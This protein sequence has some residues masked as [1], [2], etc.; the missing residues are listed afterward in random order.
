M[1]LWTLTVSGNI[2]PD[3]S[4]HVSNAAQVGLINK[5]LRIDLDD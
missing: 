3:G 5:R 2:Q 4:A 1:G